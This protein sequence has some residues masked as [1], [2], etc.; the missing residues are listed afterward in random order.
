MTITQ[1]LITTW[2]W[3]PTVLVGCLAALLGYAA[4]CRNHSVRLS[5]RR[6]EA[7]TER[8]R[9][10]FFAAALIVLLLALES[11]LDILGDT[12]LFSAHMAQH[13]L[14]VE[15]VPSLLLLGIPSPWFRRLL[16]WRPAARLEQILSCAPVAWLIGTLTMWIW[17]A[18]LLYNAALASDQIHIGQHLMFLTAGVIFWW[19][20]LAPTRTHRLASWAAAAYLASGALAGSVLGILLTFSP[21]D[22]YPAYTQP[23]DRLGILPLLRAQWGFTAGADHRLGGGLMW[24]V[25]GLVYLPAILLGVLRWLGAGDVTPGDEE[26]HLAAGPLRVAP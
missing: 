19:P 6:R 11:P 8:F 24:M 17:H 25:G 13:L 21:T 23:I 2:T 10:V 22:L 16:D 14:L 20:V 3:Q 5:A 26:A 12:Y 7:Q 9:P 18:P 15:V 1:L 4:V